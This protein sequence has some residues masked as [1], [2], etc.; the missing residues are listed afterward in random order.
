M[1]QN[2]IQDLK[3]RLQ[4]E[5]QSE[6]SYLNTREESLDKINKAYQSLSD[7][8]VDLIIDKCNYRMGC[9]INAHKYSSV[10]SQEEIEKNTAEL[11]ELVSELNNE[12]LDIENIGKEMG[13]SFEEPKYQ[14][15][16]DR[17]KSIIDATLESCNETVRKATDYLSHKFDT[18]ET[19][20]YV[21]EEVVAAPVAEVKEEEKV[22]VPEITPTDIKTDSIEDLE[23]DL[24][25][26]LKPIQE[27]KKELEEIKNDLEA[28]E[29]V[30][31]IEPVPQA[32]VAPVLQPEVNPDLNTF[33]NQ[34]VQPEEKVEEAPKDNVVGFPGSEMKSA[35]NVDEGA[36]LVTGTETFDLNEERGPVLSRAA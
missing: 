21:P 11:N 9:L 5:L 3:E 31:S 7:K 24:N 36:V 32:I 6:I 19:Q 16:A 35:A 8:N 18:I 10:A 30:T 12:I 15:F 2:N 13:N 4:A 33:L 25:N 29:R 14:D 23:R 28:P 34:G 27:D 17:I 1:N 26:Y 22:E 20:N